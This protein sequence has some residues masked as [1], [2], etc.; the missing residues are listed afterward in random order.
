MRIMI[1][2]AGL[3]LAGCQTTQ[4]LPA[5][6]PL[7]CDPIITQPLDPKPKRP[8][9]LDQFTLENNLVAE[10]LTDY[11]SKLSRSW[12]QLYARA[13]AGKAHCAGKH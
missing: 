11:A 8:A 5:V 10:L 2:C 4:T 7:A 3:V 9:D 12:D 6:A 13:V 1:L